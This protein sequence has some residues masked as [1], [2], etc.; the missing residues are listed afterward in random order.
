[1]PSMRNRSEHTVAPGVRPLRVHAF[2]MA[3]AIVLLR[4]GR[5]SSQEP[6]VVRAVSSVDPYTEGDAAAMAKAGYVSFGPFPFAH[7]HDTR[8]VMALLGDEP[9]LWVETAHFRIGCALS[10]LAL[11]GD[12]EWID[13]TKGELKRLRT[14]LPKVKAEERDLD[15]WLRTH[16]VAQR[17]EELYAEVQAN[18][19]VRDDTFPAAPGH[20]PRGD[21]QRFFG[22]GPYLGLP[23]KFS[24]L[25]VQRVSSLARYTRAHQDHETQ[26][27]RRYFDLQHR[28][29][30]WAVAEE[31]SNSLMKNDYALYTHLV[32]NLSYSLYSS[33][34]YFGSDLPPWLIAGLAHWHGR[35]I[36]PRFPAYE[37]DRDDTKL[38]QRD[39]WKWDERAPRL[40]RNGAFEPIEALMR[41][42]QSTE[43]GLEQHIQSWA[44]V[45]FLMSTRKAATMKFL[46]DMKDPFDGLRLWPKP[47][48]IH[49]RAKVCLPRAFQLDAAG[50]E[51]EWRTHVLR[52]RP[53]K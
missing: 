41:R 28:C 29:M 7:R 5:A 22:L 8:D 18:L 38:E 15:P 42:P 12:T 9:L 49:E 43:F 46:H 39:F 53:K 52:G 17:C 2:A 19:G 30:I 31:S 10:P 14:R 23:E 36:C 34:R 20:D 32:Y 40:L 47:E 4:A 6:K 35:R 21:P 27:P 50:L 16:L 26:L 51:A 13:S 48:Q 3:A 11:R 45:D 37:R 44:F 33:Y 25:I 24:V 1:M